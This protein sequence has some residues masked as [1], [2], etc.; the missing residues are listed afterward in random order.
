MLGRFFC[1]WRMDD[2][3]VENH[4]GDRSTERSVFDR[5]ARW[6]E[7]QV[8]RPIAFALAFAIIILWAVTGPFFG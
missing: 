4:G 6:T 2:R 5:F 8:G 3:M 1:A 7:H